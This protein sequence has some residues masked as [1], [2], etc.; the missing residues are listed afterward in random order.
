M[1]NLVGIKV[2]FGRQ[3]SSTNKGRSEE[4]KYFD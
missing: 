1:E 4:R 2:V 3:N